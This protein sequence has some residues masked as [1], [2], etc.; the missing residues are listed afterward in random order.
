MSVELLPPLSA[1]TE[2]IRLVD[3]QAGRRLALLARAQ[4]IIGGGETASSEERRELQARLERWRYHVLCEW[5]ARPHP[6]AQRLVETLDLAVNALAARPRRPPR[7]PREA[8]INPYF[9]PEEATRAL[10]CLDER[11][12]LAALAEEAER[13]TRRHFPAPAESSAHPLLTLT[14]ENKPQ[15]NISIPRAGAASAPL[16]AGRR[17]RLYAPLYLSSHCLNHCLYCGFRHPHRIKR[18]HLS[19]AEAIRQ[20]EMLRGRGFRHILLVAGDFPRLTPTSY[21]VEILQALRERGIQPAVEIAPQTTSGYVALAA[22]G[23]YGVTLY[24]ETYDERLYAQYHPRGPK[25]WYDWRLEG[26]ERAAEAG[27]KRLG[28]G[29]LLG[30]SEPRRELPALIRHALYLRGRFP[31]CRLAFSLPRIHETPPGFNPP[32]PVDDETFV[33][34]YC[35]LR[36]AF[37]DAELVLS[38]R[39]PP[40]LRNRLAEICITQMSAGSSTVPGGYENG[41]AAKGCGAQFPVSDTRSHQEVAH[42]LRQRGFTV[43]WELD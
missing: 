16:S 37:P 22:A 21:F 4:R 24:Q 5:R 12:P 38:T 8:A 14:S 29:I 27:I 3:P 18:R 1:L 34:L 2:W 39:E 20:A 25:N 31:D 6:L 42:W 35:A 33:R 23:A 15:D 30:L 32:C 9:V 19:P 10:A 13:L 40:E 26:L 43:Q 17:M 7:C 28:L 36:M 41:A 11:Y